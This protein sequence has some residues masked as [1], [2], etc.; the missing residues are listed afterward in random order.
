M[1]SQDRRSDL[2][3]R[4]RIDE[5]LDRVSAAREEIV[6][7]GLDAVRDSRAADETPRSGRFARTPRPGEHA[8]GGSAQ[9]PRPAG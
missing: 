9:R 6:E 4:R 5:L 2:E 1:R 8:A 7:A 3:T